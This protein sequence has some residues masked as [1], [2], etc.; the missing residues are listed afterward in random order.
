MKLDA[1]RRAQR[2]R[3][4]QAMT[5]DVALPLGMSETTDRA[6]KL[7][8]L[9]DRRRHSL[10]LAMRLDVTWPIDDVTDGPPR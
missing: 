10:G 1:T 7:D 6:M 9:A 8:A 5:R 3:G 4:D 2:S